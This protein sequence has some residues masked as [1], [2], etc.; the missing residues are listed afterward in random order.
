MF[1]VDIALSLGT[2]FTAFHHH[3]MF[4][5]EKVQPK[6]GDYFYTSRNRYSCLQN[7]STISMKSLQVA[8]SSLANL[9]NYY[10]GYRI[11]RVVHYLTEIKMLTK[12]F[13]ITYQGVHT[14]PWCGC[15]YKGVVYY[16]PGGGYAS[17]L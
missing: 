6:A 4:M 11:K 7:N 14:L 2:P 1:Q 9:Y 15:A 17:M 5:F 12:G 10:S 8:S 13:Y 16:L 3:L